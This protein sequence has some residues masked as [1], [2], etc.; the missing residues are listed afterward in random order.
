MQTNKTNKTKQIKKKTKTKKTKTNKQTKILN[1]KV[2]VRES[3]N[4]RKN[5]INSK[6]EAKQ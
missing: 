6:S 2:Y 4:K 3:K 1:A 5:N